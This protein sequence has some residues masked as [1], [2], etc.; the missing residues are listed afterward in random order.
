[1][2]PRALFAQKAR[3]LWTVGC[4]KFSFFAEL[5]LDIVWISHNLPIGHGW[6]HAVNEEDSLQ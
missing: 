5:T 2:K 6:H 1:M 3:T 4:G